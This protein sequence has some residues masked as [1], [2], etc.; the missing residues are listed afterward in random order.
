MD[1]TSY[2]RI[3]YVTIQLCKDTLPNTA[4][5]YLF[6]LNKRNTRKR[7]D[8]CSKLTMKLPERRHWNV[9]VS[10]LLTL[11]YFTPLPSFSIADY[12]QVDVCWENYQTFYSFD[13]C[14]NMPT[15][16]RQDLTRSN[17]GNS[18]FF[19]ILHTTTK[20][21][22]TQNRAWDCHESISSGHFSF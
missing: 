9:P 3:N 20:F 16:G 4:K 12:K 10:S 13:I 1:V 21:F 19:L 5:F 6:K 14:F 22:G 2:L 18:N 8:I 15:G 7:P 17:V 11:N